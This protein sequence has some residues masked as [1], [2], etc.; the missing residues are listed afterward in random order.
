[1]IVAHQCYFASD[2]PESSRRR[3]NQ[4]RVPSEPRINNAATVNIKPMALEPPKPGSTRRNHSVYSASFS[5]DGTK[6]VTATHDIPAILWDAE[7]GKELRRLQRVKR[8]DYWGYTAS[9][10]T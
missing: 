8:D 7:T 3:L 9:F 2:V 1:M 6:V 4:T 10:S 5:L